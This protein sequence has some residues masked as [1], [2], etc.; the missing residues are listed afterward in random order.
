MYLKT[1]K[2]Y[3]GGR[4]QKRHIISLRWAWLWILTPL[5]AYGAYYLNENREQYVPM[6][7][8]AIAELRESAESSVATVIAPTP[9]PTEDPAQQM[10]MTDAAWA[11]GAIEEAIS[12]YRQ[13]QTALPNDVETHYFL[14]MGLLMNGKNSEALEAA[15]NTVTANPYSPDAWAIRSMALNWTGNSGEAV[16]SALRAVELAGTNNPVA[17]ARARAFLAEAYLNEG[18]Y[19]RAI[20]MVNQALD[21]NPDSYE[22]HRA[23][24]QINQQHLF[25]FVTAMRAS[26]T[27]FELAPNLPYLAVD[28]AILHVREGETTEAIRI[29]NNV[30]EL[31]P[32]NTRAL[33]W[34]GR[35]YLQDIGD[36]NEAASYFSRC[37]DTSPDNIDC[38]Y[39]LGRSQVRQELYA[40]ALTSFEKTIELGTTNPYHIWWAARGHI[41][42]NNGCAAAIPYLQQGWEIAQRG[43]DQTII[44]SYVSQMSDC[45]LSTG[46]AFGEATPDPE[47]T[48]EAPSDDADV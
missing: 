28:L 48:E 13:L 18:Q 33:F 15:E 31:N 2:Q 44:D 37:V 11:R 7:Q 6:V 16:A 24:S 39:S 26:Q 40:N 43:T 9:L 34:L 46:P 35:T 4:R 10:A 3:T 5:V 27:A 19:E 8:E 36:P 14:T 32:N 42:A 30:V 41:L 25:D 1:P 47:E 29:L 20:T 45:Q 17:R 12:G 23:R 21:D 38:Y 22:A